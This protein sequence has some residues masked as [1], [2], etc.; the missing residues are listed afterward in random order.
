MS[1]IITNGRKTNITQQIAKKLLVL[2]IIVRYNFAFLLD[3]FQRISIL[4][5]ATVTVLH[6]FISHIS[7]DNSGLSEIQRFVL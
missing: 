6:N 4:K 5:S 7:L 2:S 3:E 1:V